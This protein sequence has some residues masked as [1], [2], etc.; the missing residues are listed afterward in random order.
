MWS[1]IILRYDMPRA[2]YLKC[3]KFN[4]KFQPHMNNFNN[5]DANSKREKKEH[6]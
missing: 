5:N 1:F 2:R 6:A 3:V 4:L